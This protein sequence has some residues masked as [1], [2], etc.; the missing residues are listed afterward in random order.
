MEVIKWMSI[1]DRHTKIFLDKH[2]DEMGPQQQ[3]VHVHSA[4]LPSA[5]DYTGLL[6]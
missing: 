2:L 6:Y 5:R 1:A 4:R 3:P